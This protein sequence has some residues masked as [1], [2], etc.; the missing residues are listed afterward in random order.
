MKPA[1]I[2]SLAV[3][4][5]AA[6][7]AFAQSAPP[8]GQTPGPDRSARLQQQI[9]TL[10][11]DGDGSLS[12]EETAG[13]K[14]LAREFDQMDANKD[15][16]LATDE[17][18]AYRKTTRMQHAARFE[19]L[20]AATDKNR[21]GVVTKAEARAS[22]VRAM[23]KHFDQMDAN[24]DGR[25]MKEEMQASIAKSTGGRGGHGARFEQKYKAADKD[26]DGTLSKEETQAAKLDR[27]TQRFDQVD[28]NKDGKLTRDELRSHMQARHK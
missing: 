8:A 27:I 6:G 16:K 3:G 20:F 18:Q 12:R 9:Q 21:D 14:W 26:G 23:A 25:L 10:D 19:E 17:I 22:N 15:A 11:K 2:L 5:F 1:C 13:H 24:G 7:A 4:L 28:A